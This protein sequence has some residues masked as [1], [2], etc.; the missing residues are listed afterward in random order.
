MKLT[1]PLKFVA[2]TAL[3]SFVVVALLKDSLLPLNAIGPAC[4]RVVNVKGYLM[5]D[6]TDSAVLT[7]PAG[8]TLFV[9][10]ITSDDIP[11][12]PAFEVLVDG[13]PTTTVSRK[14]S[15]EGYESHFS[16]GI[17]VKGGQ[18]LGIRS[19]YGFT[20]TYEISIAAVV[21]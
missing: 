9:R 7:V 13:V 14:S 17:L 20:G 18:E 16:C 5:G 19:L 3:A 2:M 6:F 8:R 1:A 11:P 21:K 15:A 10:D 4:D 12:A